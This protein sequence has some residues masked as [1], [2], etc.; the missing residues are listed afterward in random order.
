MT[1]FF[2]KNAKDAWRLKV[3]EVAKQ[4]PQHTFQFL[5]KRPQNIIPFLNRTGAEFSTNVWVG[6]TVENRK[7]LKRIDHLRMV[8]ANIKYLSVEPLLEDLGEINLDGID[9]TI[10]GGESGRGARPMKASWVKKIRHQCKEAGV[11][12]FFKQWGTHPESN[13]L[14]KKTPD[15]MKVSDWVAKHDPHG[16]GGALI[17]GKLCRKMPKEKLSQS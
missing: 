14:A 9:L 15:G 11:A 13:P 17:N 4:C 6:T 12:F 10:V 3:L 1:D 16:K 2:H 5:T 8:P 7:T